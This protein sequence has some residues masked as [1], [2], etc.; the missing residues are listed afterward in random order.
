M[1]I[2]ENLSGNSGVTFFEISEQSIIVQFG[3]GWSYRYTN[4]STEQS[5]LAMM[6][7]LALRGRGLGSFISRNVYESYEEKWR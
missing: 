7:K 1:E 6:K 2:Y 5:D 3:N 4:Q